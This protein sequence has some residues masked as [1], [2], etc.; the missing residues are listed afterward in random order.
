MVKAHL[1]NHQ[2]IFFPMEKSDWS[3]DFGKPRPDRKV[4]Y[5]DHASD[6]W[7]SSFTAILLMLMICGKLPAFAHKHQEVK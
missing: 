4:A 5:G 3:M 1:R 7:R 6:E 2:Q